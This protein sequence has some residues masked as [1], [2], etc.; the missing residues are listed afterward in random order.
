MQSMFSYHNGMELEISSKRKFGKLINM[1]KLN[2]TLP[3]NQW[4]KKE[5]KREVRKYIQL[6]ENKTQH[7][8]TYGCNECSA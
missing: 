5:L 3:N 7:V 2:N 4:V 1:F 8:K 6:N